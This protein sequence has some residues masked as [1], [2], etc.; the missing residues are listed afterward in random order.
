MSLDKSDRKVQPLVK[1]LQEI[2]RIQLKTTVFEFEH[3]TQRD[4][5]QIKKWNRLA[6]DESNPNKLDSIDFANSVASQWAEAREKRLLADN[7][8]DFCALIQNNPH[9]EVSVFVVVKALQRS[10]RKLVA[11][12]YFRRTWC[13][14]I[15]LDYVAVHPSLVD[16]P[17]RPIRDTGTVILYFIAWLAET[18]GARAVWGMTTQN[19]VEFYRR[20]F[21]GKRIK[22][23]LYL[24]EK[25]YKRFRESVDTLKETK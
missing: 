2:R 21:G 5:R 9:E 23:L 12:V 10:R 20:I 14:N 8:H 16:E 4:M 3:G 18:I 11:L 24:T 22:D 19:S 1:R 17:N 25:D 6:R 13:N 7:W 15:Y